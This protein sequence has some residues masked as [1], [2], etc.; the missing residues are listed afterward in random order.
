MA[1]LAKLGCFEL[2]ADFFQAYELQLAYQGGDKIQ[3]LLVS[4]S[5]PSTGTI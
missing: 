4:Y 2:T 1:Q 3:Y 5:S